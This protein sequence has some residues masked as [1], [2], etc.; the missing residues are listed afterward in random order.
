MWIKDQY[1]DIFSRWVY[2]MKTARES[3]V[4]AAAIGRWTATSRLLPASPAVPL[5]IIFASF[6]LNI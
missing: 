5:Y 6:S 3:R 2:R 4:D 1:L